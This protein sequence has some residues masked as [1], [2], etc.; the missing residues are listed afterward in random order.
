MFLWRSTASKYVLKK[1]KKKSLVQRNDRRSEVGGTGKMCVGRGRL[2]GLLLV[3]SAQ[4]R[5]ILTQRWKLS[6]TAT[7]DYKISAGSHLWKCSEICWSIAAASEESPIKAVKVLCDGKRPKTLRQFLT[8]WNGNLNFG[9][10]IICAVF[11]A[12][13]WHTLRHLL[14]RYDIAKFFIH[15]FKVLF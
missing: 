1:R 3:C 8:R 12:I 6:E 14:V 10:L 4:V 2:A 11:V 9:C 5:F 7:M 15:I 13:M